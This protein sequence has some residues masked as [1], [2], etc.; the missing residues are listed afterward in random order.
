MGIK[1]QFEKDDSKMIG[2][3]LGA[4]LTDS[5]DKLPTVRQYNILEEP[6]SPAK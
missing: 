1:D 3:G 5:Y 4:Q 6:I 2:S